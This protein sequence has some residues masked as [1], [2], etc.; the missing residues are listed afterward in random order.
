MPFSLV[1][2]NLAGML[3]PHTGQFRESMPHMLRYGTKRERD[4]SY[5]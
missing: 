1:A 3:Q 2:D 4:I 5:T